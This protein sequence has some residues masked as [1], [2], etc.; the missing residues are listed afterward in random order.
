MVGCRRHPE[1]REQASA[2]LLIGAIGAMVAAHRPCHSVRASLRIG[3]MSTKGDGYSQIAEF[4]RRLFSAEYAKT[5]TIVT[6]AAFILAAL[7]GLD[8]HGVTA[9]LILAAVT[10]AVAFALLASLLEGW[11]KLKNRR[12]EERFRRLRPALE[13]HF[14]ALQEHGAADPLESDRLAEELLAL[15]LWLTNDQ[16]NDPRV[17]RSLISSARRGWL[18]GVR[19]HYPPLF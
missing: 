11:Q 4:L 19:R 12:A 5:K 17:L 14:R 7:P 15:D 18:D 10:S 13:A 2:G 6:G 8:R 16:M 1:L 9:G 3:T